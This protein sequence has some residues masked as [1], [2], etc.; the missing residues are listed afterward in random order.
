MPVAVYKKERIYP[1]LSVCAKS[2]ASV[3]VLRP[4][5]CA[6]ACC[7]VHYNKALHLGRSNDAGDLSAVDK[8]ASPSAAIVLTMSF[9][10]L[11]ML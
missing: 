5:L 10:S 7:S 4:P 11:P 6:V 8:N 3:V 2:R 9:R 1:V